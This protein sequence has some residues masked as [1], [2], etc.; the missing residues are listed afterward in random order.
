MRHKLLIALMAL[1]LTFGGC[2]GL[3]GNRL[4]EPLSTP[5]PIP[6]P[7]LTSTT[8]PRWSWCL[9]CTDNLVN[10]WMDGKNKNIGLRP[11]FRHGATILAQVSGEVRFVD[12]WEDRFEMVDDDK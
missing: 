12:I 8:T 5:T 2:V 9:G 7:T 11:Y 6:T 3:G 1:L 10:V 4:D